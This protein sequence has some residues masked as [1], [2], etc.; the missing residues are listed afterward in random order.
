MISELLSSFWGIIGWFSIMLLPGAWVTFGLPLPRFPFCLKLLVGTAFAPVVVFVQFYALRI[1]GASFETTVPLLVLINLPALYLIYKRRGKMSFP[2]FK[3]LLG[4]IVV[5][6][7]PLA[8]LVPQLLDSQVRVFTGHG[9][10]QSDIVYM[11][12][13]GSLRLEEPELAGLKMVYPWAAH[14]FQAVLSYLLNSAPASSYIWT[15]LVVLS[16]MYGFSAYTV[17]ELGGNRLSRITSFLWLCFGLNF[18]GYVFFIMIP[19]AIHGTFWDHGPYYYAWIGGDYR[20][21]PWMLKFFFFEQS[22]FGICMLS[23]VIYILIKERASGLTL[24]SL[25]LLGLLLCGIG[26]VYP[27][28]FAPAAIG[29]CCAAF[30]FF[31]DRA[32]PEKPDY[33]QQCL[34]LG[35][36]LIAAAAV[37]Y[38]NVKSLSVDRT[39]P[40][41]ILPSLSL[42]FAKYTLIKSVSSAVVLALLLG[43]LGFAFR[44]CW[45]DNRNATIILAG[46]GLGS[47][48]LYLFLEIPKPSAEY[49]FL[50]TAA[51]FFAPFPALALQPYL[52]RL[53]GKALPVFALI[54][55]ALAAP[56]AHKIYT[57]F[58]WT[59]PWPHPAA[60]AGSFDLRLKENE[61]MSPLCDAIRQKTPPDAILVVE[62]SNVHFPTLTHRRLYAPPL[63]DKPHAGVFIMSDLLLA[64]QKGYGKEIIAD[65]RLV[66]NELFNSPDYIRREQSV[67]HILGLKAPVAIILEMPRHAALQEWLATDARNSRL[68]DDGVM[69]LWLI[70]P[71]AKTN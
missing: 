34:G 50:L 18:A 5:L 10:M 42:H 62:K 15:N 30:A 32:G 24:D 9:W 65:R 61:P 43:G 64:T 48:L 60:D 28:Y 41:M 7:I 11:L 22:I 57:D 27:V 37:T 44:R 47:A 54:A 3:T 35:V 40:S 39:T 45:K 2:G 16:C 26:L 33:F 23:S 66:V 36:V 31:L 69:T 21:F 20:I 56:A 29:V 59:P 55:F 51:L 52:E 12:A 13:D 38:A 46:G 63:Q 70:V 14:P 71:R 58:P 25:I 49:K 17:A 4:A 67:E 6:L 19:G 1:L 8:L 53:K 68:F